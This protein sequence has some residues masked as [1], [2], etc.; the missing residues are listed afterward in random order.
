MGIV[1]CLALA[2]VLSG[3][4]L[5]VFSISRLKL[6]VEAAGGSREAIRVLAL[7]K[8]ANFL[9]ATI[10]WSNVA[11]NVLLTLLSNSALK[12]IEAFAFST[13]AITLLGELLPQAYFS[14]NA[15]RVSARLAPM[16]HVLRVA[17]F[18]IAKPTALLLDCWLG[19]EAAALFKERDFPALLT[20]HAEVESTGLGRLEVIG[21][22]NFLQLDDIDVQ[23]EGEPVDPLS[24]I[25]LPMKND[26]P[27]FPPFVASP[28]DAFLR[29][30]DASG[31]KWVI[32]V[33]AAGEPH[34]VLNAHHFLRD[35][36]FDEVSV[37]PQAYWHRPIVVTDPR[38]RLGEVIGRMEAR[39]AHPEAD[40]IDNDLILFWGE[41]KRIITGADL[42]GRLLRGIALREAQR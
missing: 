31:K 15:M 17:L 13:A 24:I 12:G 38:T 35:A 25:A 39:S 11:A 19:S 34:M 7:R 36:L 10:I 3:L 28:N 5:A 8:D 4:N 6:E 18:P 21:A 29:R 20:K 33:D 2:G 9:L 26:R 40:V 42:L 41:R 1:A 32:L 14:R 30:L 16:L 23:D 27:L 22:L 37:G